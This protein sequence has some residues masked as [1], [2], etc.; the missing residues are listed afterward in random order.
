MASR[1]AATSHVEISLSSLSSDLLMRVAN[2]LGVKELCVFDT[3]TENSKQLRAKYLSGLRND[4][5]LYPGADV[6]MKT[7]EWQEGY[8]QWLT[9]RHVF[10]NS[11]SLNEQTTATAFVLYDTM[12][13]V[14]PSLATLTIYGNVTFPKDMAVRN[15]MTLHKLALLDQG[16]FG[17]AQLRK[18]MRSVLEWESVGGSLQELKLVDC[19]FGN[20]A[21]DFGKTCDALTELTI[22]NCSSTLSTTPGDSL[23]CTRLLWGI[24]PKCAN[25]KKFTFLHDRN[26]DCVLKDR[27]LCLLARFCPHLTQ[28]YIQSELASFSEAALGCVA[29]KC[30]KLETL[31]LPVEITFTDRTIEA[32][33]A[34]LVSLRLIYFRELQLE[35]SRTLRGLTEGCRQLQELGIMKGSVPEVELLYL[36]KHAKKL[37]TLNIGKW[38]HLDFRERWAELQPDTS[39]VEDLLQLGMEDPEALITAQQDRLKSI[40]AATQQPG[41]IDEMDTVCKLR[42]ASSNPDFVCGLYAT[43]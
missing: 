20:E 4:T 7:S 32:I 39:A 23:G 41:G 33:A 42:A 12:N 43:V 38:K 28:L 37:D 26:K 9:M 6:E 13:R 18:F 3:A 5:F 25:L 22:E 24:L 1:A 2:Y 36:V 40:R 31:E 30:T 35:N 10:V 34:N 29:M 19:T 17:T 8:T 16:K 27:D 21:I 15:K 14:N 11:I